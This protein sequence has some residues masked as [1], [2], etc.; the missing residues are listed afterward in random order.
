MFAAMPDTENLIT[1]ITRIA[2]RYRLVPTLSGRIIPVPVFTTDSGFKK[3]RGLQGS[4]YLVQGSAY[5]VLAEALVRTTSGSGCRPNAIPR[6]RKRQASSCSDYPR[7]SFRPS[8]CNRIYSAETAVARL[9]K[10]V[11]DRLKRRA[12]RLFLS[13]LKS[14]WSPLTGSFLSGAALDEPGRNSFIQDLELVA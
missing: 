7:S 11:K 3:G 2:D 10:D 12:K 1:K 6:F 4:N 5:D 13:F 8:R 14:R 9:P